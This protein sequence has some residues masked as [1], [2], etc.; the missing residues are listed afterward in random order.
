MSTLSLKCSKWVVDNQ[1]CLGMSLLYLEQTQA[2]LFRDK[3]I[4]I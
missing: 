2:F 4:E 1:S 3:V